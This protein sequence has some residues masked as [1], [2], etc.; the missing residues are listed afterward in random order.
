MLSYTEAMFIDLVKTVYPEK[1]F[2]QIPFPRMTM[3]AESMEK[4]GSDKPDI[5]VNKEDPN[6]LGFVWVLDF[7]MFETLEDGTLKHSIIHFVQ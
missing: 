4:Y 6:E 7:P 3:Y 5:R 1:T 2:T